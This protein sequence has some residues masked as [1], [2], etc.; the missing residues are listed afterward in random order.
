MITIS[1]ILKIPNLTFNKYSE[2]FTKQDTGYP[3]YKTIK[4]SYWLNHPGDDGTIRE[5]SYGALSHGEK[6]TKD[7]DISD[8]LITSRYFTGSDYS[9]TTVELSNYEVFKELYG[10]LN[11]VYDVYGGYSTFSMAISVK[12]LL[13]PDNEDKAIEI[14]ETLKALSDYPLIDDEHLSNMEYEKEIEYITQDWYK[15]ELPRM[16]KEKLNVESYDIDPDTAWELYRDLSELSNSYPTFETNGYPYIDDDRLKE[17]LT[18]DLLKK[19]NIKYEV[20]ES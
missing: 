15:R 5:M 1:D 4:E 17:Y 19:Y 2:Y 18:I 7:T 6:I 13:N 3:E 9:G 14:L 11:G 20:V 12:W 16:I 8:M 10:D